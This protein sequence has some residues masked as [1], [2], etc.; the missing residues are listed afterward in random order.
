M[1]PRGACFN[2]ITGLINHT[3][4]LLTFQSLFSGLAASFAAG[5][6]SSLVFFFSF[7]LAG[8]GQGKPR[9]PT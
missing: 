6:D 3:G 4:I 9:K 2:T 8:F 5:L 1:R 7:L